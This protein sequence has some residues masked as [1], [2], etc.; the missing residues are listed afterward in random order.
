MITVIGNLKGGTGKSTVAFNLSL[1][2]TRNRNVHVIAYD[3]DPQATL[4]D[5]FEIRTEEGY[6]PSITPENRVDN[7]GKEGAYSEVIVDIG[8]SDMGAFKY[9]LTKA[10]RVIIPI[11]PSQ[12][13]VWS[14]QRFLK[15]LTEYC[16]SDKRPQVF[17]FMNKADTHHAVRETDDAYEALLTLSDHITMLEPRLYQRTIFR[18]SFS[19][20]RAV[21]ELDRRSKATAELA[22]LGELLY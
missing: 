20:G 4:S 19:E 13:D 11:G 5:A 6:T 8:M 3:L 21:F 1:W 14:T 12:A 15:M 2:L 7:L 10:D 16:N 17:G 22:Q 18:R 9:A